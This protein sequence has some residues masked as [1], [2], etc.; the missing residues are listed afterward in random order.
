MTP[1]CFAALLAAIWIGSAIG[2][3]SQPARRQPR[4]GPDPF[5]L[6]INSAAS[7][8]VDSPATVFAEFDPP[9]IPV[10][11]HSIYRVVVT[12]LEESLEAPGKLNGPTGLEI[13]AGGHGQT[14]A[15]TFQMSPAPGTPQ[16]RMQPQTTF[17]YHVTA[18]NIGSLAIRPFDL[19]AYGKPLKVPEAKLMVVPAGGVAGQDRPLLYAEFPQGDVYVGQTL[20]VPIMLPVNTPGGA[21]GIS[22]AKINGEFLF[23]EPY[24]LGYRTENITQNGKSFI[25]VTTDVMVTL[26]HE[27]RQELIAQGFCPVVRPMPGQTNVYQ[28]M[29][30]L[31][32]SDPVTVSV[33]P[34]PEAGRLPGFTGA[35]GNYRV[36]SPRLSTD[37]VLA[38]QPVTLTFNVRGDGNLGRITL[39]P[40]PESSDWQGFLPAADNSLP[41]I[42][43]QQRGFVTFSYTLIP[44]KEGVSETPAILFSC[45][46][47]QKKVYVDLTVPPLAINVRHNP[48]VVS[49]ITN[50]G[51]TN[52]PAFREED[53]ADKE[54]EPVLAGLAK[55][56]GT[57]AASLAPLQSRGWFLGFQLVPAAMLGGLW[58]RDRRR[59]FLQAH[60]EV[61]L[62]RRARRGLRRQLRLARRAAARQNAAGFV[63][64]AANAFREACAPHTA[65]TPEALVCADV[66]R[67][68]PES[69]R[70]GRNGEIVRRLFSADDSLRFGGPN[71]EGPSLLAMQ[72]E[73]E[74]LLKQMRVRLS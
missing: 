69:E 14:Y 42:Y 55:T 54:P 28:N 41:P 49:A 66:L 74:S 10:G 73:L 50:A 8:D 24:N 1:G 34:L 51:A 6:M 30:L 46:D 38:G 20:K 67:E 18:T 48:T 45:F 17:L 61:I 36:D 40:F 15:Q 57:A 33:K 43:V 25:A 23:S 29:N 19:T 53:P 11:G 16:M 26:L 56:P 7:F 62:K 68:L 39:P 64:S 13:H 9:V 65:A 37:D 52:L 59:R 70:E 2:Q 4:P 5:D 71:G 12:A 3:P 60:P 21:R 32:D 22:G 58:A 63:G 47:P 31:M 27:G 35:V 44:V 72:P